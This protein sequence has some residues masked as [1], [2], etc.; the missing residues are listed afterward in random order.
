MVAAGVLLAG[1]VPPVDDAPLP[2]VL[3]ATV[4]PVVDAF[5]EGA[6]VEGVVEGAIVDGTVE[7]VVVTVDPASELLSGFVLATVDMSQ[8][9]QVNEW[10]VWYLQ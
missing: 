8:R 9:V 10:A 2:V 7:G 5:V 4:D 3:P 6:V 1:A